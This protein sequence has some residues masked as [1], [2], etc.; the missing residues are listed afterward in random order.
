MA[1][2]LG[3]RLNAWAG[4][5]SNGNKVKRLHALARRSVLQSEL[6]SH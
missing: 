2:G 1:S 6:L 5:L 4:T 3:I